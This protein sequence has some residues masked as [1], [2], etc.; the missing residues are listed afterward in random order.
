MSVGL[1]NRRALIAGLGSA[2]VWPVVARAQQPGRTYRLA[3]ISGLSHDNPLIAA[4]FDELRL[5]GMIEGQNLQLIPGGFYRRYEELRETIPANVKSAPDAI[6]C[7]GD[8]AARA[9]LEATKTLPLVAISD[10]MVE[11]GL[12]KSLAR[13]GGNMTGVSLLATDLDGKRQ[14]VL[15]EAV[16]AARQI[17]ALRDANVPSRQLQSLQTSAR[18]RGVD[19]SILAVAKADEI[20]PAMDAA[21]ASGAAALNVLASQFTFINRRLI[22]ERAEALRLPSMYQWPETAEEGGFAAYGPRFSQV[23]RQAARIVVRVLRGAKPADIPVEQ[24]TN[25]ELVINLKTAKA[26]GHDVPAGLML[27]TDKVIE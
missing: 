20:A 5:S 26:I 14:D 15:M 17:A 8:I 18:A 2:A 22:I 25:F 13:P 4:F 19:L 27:R 24:P 1:T 12:V 11:A 10:D 7:G 3:F 16:P 23:W 9:L 6:F 21:K